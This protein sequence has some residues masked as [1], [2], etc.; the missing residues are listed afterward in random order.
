[1]LIELIGPSGIGKTTAIRGLEKTSVGRRSDFRSYD[2]YMDMRRFHE[3]GR[4][5][6]EPGLLPLLWRHPR[7]VASV[8]SLAL[9]HG[10]P[11]RRRMRKAF[12]CLANLAI[13]ERL[14][15]RHPDDLIVI[16]DGFMQT[17]WSLVVESRALRG[18][19]LMRIA[20]ADYQRA[21]KQRAIRLRVDHEEIEERV[22]ARESG[23]RFNRHAGPA[24]REAYR[25]WLDYFEEIAALAPPGMIVSEIDGR[26]DPDLVAA[27]LAE[28]IEAIAPAAPSP[29]NT[30]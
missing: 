6:E 24:V 22:F 10:P 2:D 30:P 14:R 21:I 12:R 3:E 9:L 15:E 20:L 26:R 17:L 18:R 11:L 4:V 7:L 28:A 19:R 25:K 1:M 27:S 13:T 23:G 16:D 8:V 29:S 5:G